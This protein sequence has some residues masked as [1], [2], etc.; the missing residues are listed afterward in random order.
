MTRESIFNELKT[1][2]KMVKPN[3][4]TEAL[5]E[6]TR[7]IEDLGLDSLTILLLSFAIEKKFEFKFDGA[8]KFASVGEVMDY[9]EKHTA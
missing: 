5:T 4:D 8:P 2:F 9:I 7:L 1:I 3:I 6:G